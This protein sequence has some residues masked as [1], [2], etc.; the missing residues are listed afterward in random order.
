MS[1]A[2]V[3][4]PLQ[5]VKW[6]QNFVAGAYWWYWH[7]SGRPNT[8]LPLQIIC[9]GRPIW[10]KNAYFFVLTTAE[11]FFKYY[12]MGVAKNK[13]IT[14]IGTSSKEYL[15]IDTTWDPPY[16]SP[17]SPFKAGLLMGLLFANLSLGVDWHWALQ[18]LNSG[19]K[20]LQVTITQRWQKDKDDCY[21]DIY[22]EEDGLI[23]IMMIDRLI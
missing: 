14:S 12:L 23:E 17:D 13:K 22:Y 19:F 7:F 16:I 9:S 3:G 21:I 4:L 20:Y 1:T 11:G 5:I 8:G 10:P 2:P 6:K 15:S 18:F